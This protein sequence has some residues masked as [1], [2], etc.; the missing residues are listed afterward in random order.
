MAG[1]PIQFHFL[2]FSVVLVSEVALLFKT[3]EPCLI[4]DSRPYHNKLIIFILIRNCLY[5]L[6]VISALRAMAHACCHLH[7]INEA[8]V[9]S[10]QGKNLK[11]EKAEVWFCQCNQEAA[12]ETR[13]ISI[14]QSKLVIIYAALLKRHYRL[15]R[16]LESDG[17]L[18]H[19]IQARAKSQQLMQIENGLETQ[20][21]FQNQSRWKSLLQ[22]VYLDFFSLNFK[23]QPHKEVT[24]KTR[25]R[26]KGSIWTAHILMMN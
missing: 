12:M 8:D 14:M 26:N 19:W 25:L 7:W 6:P 3:R 2:Y 11:S 5:Y 18:P 20:R 9:L 15:Q 13:E 17:L 24:T 10:F 16:F 4:A 21:K 23:E 22:L 1:L